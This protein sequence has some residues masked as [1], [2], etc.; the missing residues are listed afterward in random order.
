MAF[1]G[2]EEQLKELQ[3]R[4]KFA[5]A[6][7]FLALGLLTA[8]LV[9]LQIF[10]GDK[11]R[12]Y[13][14]ENRIK[15]VR[16]PA[17]RGM[18][19]D[20]NHI[21]LVDNQ[22]A[23]DL[24]I[25]PQYLRESGEVEEVL[26]LVA[27]L[28]GEPLES[29]RAKLEQSRHQPSFVPVK[30][31]ND[32]TRDEVATLE[33]WKISTPGVSVKMEIQRT[34]VHGDT[35]AHL[36]GYIGKV[37]SSEHI[38]LREA[39]K[40]YRLGDQIGKIGIEK[41]MEDYLRGVDG[42]ELIEVDALGRR[43]RDEVQGIFGGLK[44]VKEIPGQNIFLTIDQDLQLAAKE[45]FGDRVGS[46]V[47]IDPRSGEVLAMISRPSFDPTEFSR[48]ISPDL[49]RELLNDPA[50]PLRDKAIQDHY[51]PGSVFKKVT[52]I[53][54]L[55]EAVITPDTVVNCPG[56]LRIG[57]RVYRCHKR[58][59]HGDVNVVSALAQSCNVF[60][61]RIAQKM[62]SIDLIAQWSEKLGLGQRT[63][64]NLPREV[65]GLIATEAWRKERL[66][67][68]WTPGL[69]A[70]MSIGQGDV[71]TTV[72][73]LANLNA[74]IAN[75][76]TLYR[77]NYVNRIESHTG[78]IIREFKPEILNQVKISEETLRNVTQG[79]WGAMNHTTGTGYWQRIKGADFAGKTGT[80]QNL[81]IPADQGNVRCDDL[82]PQNRHHAVFA[83]FAPANDAK[84]AVAILA[85]H[86][87][88]GSS[89]AAPVA[90]AVIKKYLEKYEPQL[91]E[92]PS[93]HL[94]TGGMEDAE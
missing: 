15:R 21:L 91:F 48:G 39:G 11:F 4:F 23:F 84:I 44:E 17:P 43:I 88:Y 68:P 81:R 79:L 5:F 46:L 53:A 76:G 77:P 64:I 16:I 10:N 72:L 54:A 28:I 55:E 36:L 61:Y 40:S 41:E 62:Q 37:N 86:G 74:A 70:N 94:S 82:K 47:A 59:G 45:A 80:S 7:L 19:F 26:K 1:L 93:R 67:Q 31:K 20:R 27:D 24:E 56:H 78:Q 58:S 90:R 63:Q 60:F 92:K 14:E 35:A 51:M 85:E 42:Q 3:D 30:I 89:G 83:G 50:R 8:R 66:G 25:T 13:S 49:W 32:L 69:T 12:H 75:G 29:I 6:I 71:L 9:Y 57:N 87:C 38:Q 2:G 22:P 34:N 18:I 73:Q 33:S 52:A 65:P